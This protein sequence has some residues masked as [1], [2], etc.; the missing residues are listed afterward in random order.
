M[1]ESSTV[2]IGVVQWQMRYYGG[3]EELLQELE[4]KVKAQVAY[5]TDFILL[6]EFFSAPLLALD[7]VP[8]SLR[9]MQNLA[10]LSPLIV[11]KLCQLSRSHEVNIV[12][13]TLPV[14]SHGALT[15]VCYICQRN[16]KVHAQAKLHVTP[17][18]VQDWNM[19][20]GS[21]LEVF[22]IDKI[23]VG[24]LVCYDIEF[25]ELARLQTKQGMQ[26]LFVPSWTDARHGYLR[27]RH[28]AA[29]RAIENE[30]YV[31]LSSSVG[32]L[33]VVPSLDNQYGQSVVLTPAD[34]GFPRDAIAA[35]AETN[36]PME[37]V[38]DLDLSLL[39]KL[40]KAGSV[41]NY[42]D[43]RNDL[44]DLAWIGENT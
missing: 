34:Y 3:L 41:R 12:A 15:N 19:V 10:Q 44:Y 31:A 30:C 36:I 25:P 24:V 29:A 11:E 8:G 20:G 23:K 39:E 43:R 9:A 32:M 33:P 22:E 7:S 35:E 26:L 38:V 6:P 5:G 2:R 42:Q 18:E 27:V 28:C 21:K 40:R 4:R 16:G 13:G 1:S 14:L 37:L 17:G